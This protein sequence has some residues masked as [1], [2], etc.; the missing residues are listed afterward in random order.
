MK[1]S[2]VIGGLA[3]ALVLAGAAQA[4]S[5]DVVYWGKDS[6][7]T[8]VVDG[9]SYSLSD[10]F[11]WVTVKDIYT[12]THT[13]TLYA[14]GTT[15]SR[16]FTLSYDNTYSNDDKGQNWCMDLE[17]NSADILDPDTCDEMV[18]YYYDGW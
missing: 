18:D 4:G 15:M 9:Q 10:A 6:H 2:A 13:L 17:D 5:L 7:A 1:L 3:A 11:D 16:D 8:V 12:G 14:N